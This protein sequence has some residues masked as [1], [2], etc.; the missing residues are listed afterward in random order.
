MSKLEVFIKRS[1]LIA[2]LF[3]VWKELAFNNLHFFKGI[4][5]VFSAYFEVSD[6]NTKK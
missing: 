5:I 4:G 3:Y 2:T 6:I 1:I